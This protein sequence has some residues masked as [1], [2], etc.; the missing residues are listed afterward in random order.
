LNI[1]GAG[2][3]IFES[4]LR[5]LDAA[6]AE[7]RRRGVGAVFVQNTFGT[8]L[9]GETIARSIQRGL[10]SF[11]LH[12]TAGAVSEFDSTGAI[13][14]LPGEHGPDIR[15]VSISVDGTHCREIAGALSPVLDAIGSKD[16]CAAVAT[17]FDRD[18]GPEAASTFVLLSFRTDTK[19]QRTGPLQAFDACVAAATSNAAKPWVVAR[20]WPQ[21]WAHA[22][23]EGLEIAQEAWQHLFKLVA[24]VRVPT[25]ERSQK[26]AG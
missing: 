15:A 1:D 3:S 18:P 8:F 26:Q 14:G 17:F 11:V 4:G 10:S 6:N 25:S 16:L 21:R 7:A 22:V 2:K 5:A 9:L 20:D 23:G 12:Q 19:A 24:R 13:L